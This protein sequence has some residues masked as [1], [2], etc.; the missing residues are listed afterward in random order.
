MTPVLTLADAGESTNI[1]GS[2]YYISDGR[3]LTR[4]TGLRMAGL[5]VPIATFCKECYT[6]SMLCQNHYTIS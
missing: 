4:A 3:W 6:Q 2:W 1:A 5:I